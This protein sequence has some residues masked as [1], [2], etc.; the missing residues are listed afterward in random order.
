MVQFV[1]CFMSP[2]MGLEAGVPGVDAQSKPEQHSALAGMY[3]VT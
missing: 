3:I 1:L 2:E